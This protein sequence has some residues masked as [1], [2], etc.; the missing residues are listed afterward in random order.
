LSERLDAR[1]VAL[2]ALLTAIWGGSFT[3]VKVG[4]RDLPVFGSLALRL[5]VAAGLLFLYSRWAGVPLRYGARGNRFLLAGTAAFVWSQSLLYLGL[6]LT[7]AGRGSIFF[8]TQPFFTLL[9]MP[10]FVPEE[11]L[12]ARKLSGTALA[13]GGVV[14]LFLEKIGGARAHA[15]LGDILTLL[16][17]LGWSASNILAKRA[18]RDLHAASF[19][20]WGAAGGVPVMAGLT[21]LLEREQPWRLTLPA[22]AS[23]LYLGGVAAAFSFVAFTWLIRRYPALRVNALVFLTPVFGVLI[24]WV[25]LG[26]PMSPAQA[27]GAGLVGAGILI[28]NTER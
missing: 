9:L 5:L 7:T 26:E 20:L 12:T 11:A 21:W 22:V 1:A 3:F 8:N 4:L 6:A 15:I 23:V 28:V 10:L 27:A 13:F 2:M 14:L 18:P 16:A 19:I 25:L 17:A 24:G